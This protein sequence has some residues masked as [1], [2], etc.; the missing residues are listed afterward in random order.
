MP[1]ILPKR[2]PLTID[3]DDTVANADWT[4]TTWDL[5]ANSLDELRRW[6]KHSGRTLE[7]FK[8]LPVYQHNVARLPWLRK[9]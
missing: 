6:L 4:K 1:Q 9:L 2:Q 5:P 7:E 8:T 3:L